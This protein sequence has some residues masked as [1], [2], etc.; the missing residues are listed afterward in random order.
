M[1]RHTALLP[2]PLAP[3]DYDT[4]MSEGSQ[5]SQPEGSPFPS[6]SDD[7]EGGA[8]SGRSRWVLGA[9]LWGCAT[10]QQR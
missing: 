1:L 6:D 9:G 8:H 4:D 2:L 10:R 7:E 3:Q 5:P